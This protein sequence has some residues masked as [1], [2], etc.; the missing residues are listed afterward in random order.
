MAASLPKLCFYGNL[1]KVRAALARGEEVNQFVLGFTGLTWATVAGHEAVVEL[2][3]KHP[4][5][6]VNLAAGQPCMT[7]LQSACMRGHAG[8]VR[9]LLAHP[10]LTCHNAVDICGRSALSLAVKSYSVECV[11]Q[12]V[13]V[14]GVDLEARDMWGRSLE[15]V[16][17]VEIWQVGK[18]YFWRKTQKSL[19]LPYQFKET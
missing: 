3:L 9:R 14:K 7:A 11:R 5:L 2:L 1:K 6:D 12:L 16:A 19:F 4:V 10:S 13:A 18:N 8:I 17:S 15:E